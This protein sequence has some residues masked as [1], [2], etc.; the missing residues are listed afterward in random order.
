MVCTLVGKVKKAYSLTDE[1]TGGTKKGMSCRLS[2]HVDP[3]ENNPKEQ[4]YG[5]GDR[6]IE[7]RCPENICDAV[8]VGN[9]LSVETDDKIT[10]VKSVMV[11]IDGGGFMP[12]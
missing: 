7:L 9:T 12:L 1:K 11:Q 6:F 5:E 8:E 3:Y 4:I 2:L 10:R